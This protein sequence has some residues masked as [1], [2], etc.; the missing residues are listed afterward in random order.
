MR[1]YT[2]GQ[3]RCASEI[4]DVLIFALLF[5]K[6]VGVSPIEAIRSK[7]EEN[8]GTPYTLHGTTSA[9][10]AGKKIQ[11]PKES[12]HWPSADALEKHNTFATM[13]RAKPV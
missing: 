12:R 6:A 5:C 9:S 13:R 4:A 10:I 1:V 11:L 7:L 2:D 8:A 3:W